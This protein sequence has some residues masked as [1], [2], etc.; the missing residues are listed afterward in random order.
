MKIVKFNLK[1]QYEQ[2]IQEFNKNKS[3]L[4]YYKIS[5]THADLI[6]SK[7]KV[8]IKWRNQLR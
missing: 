1:G 2:A 8:L 3:S 5:F 7:S 6:L 4:D